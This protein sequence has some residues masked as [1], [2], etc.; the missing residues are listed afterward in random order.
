MLQ[1][2]LLYFSWSTGQ[3]EHIG[4]WTQI[5]AGGRF[6]P[7]HSPAKCLPL[8]R[9]DGWCRSHSSIP[10][11]WWALSSVNW[12]ATAW[13]TWRRESGTS[14]SNPPSHPLLPPALRTQRGKIGFSFLEVKH[15]NSKDITEE[16]GSTAPHGYPLKSDD[17]LRPQANLKTIFWH[18]L[19]ARLWHLQRKM[20]DSRSECAQWSWGLS[21]ER[22]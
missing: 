21:A 19:A 4:I 17:L 7:N 5:L 8:V 1:F 16:G 9:R 22:C 14:W 12:W 6:S 11:L 3:Y 13:I 20:G 18:L 10:D 2:I 15:D